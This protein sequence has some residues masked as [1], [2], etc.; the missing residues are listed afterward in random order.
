[1]QDTVHIALGINDPQGDYSRHAGAML[2]SL[3]MHASGPVIAHIIHNDS[4]TAANRQKLQQV[5]QRFGKEV[6]FYPVQ[7]PAS[8]RP[9]AG[10][11]TEG[12]LF[13]LLLPELVSVD[14]II[15]F[16]CDIVVTLDIALLWNIDLAGRPVAAVLDP[17]IPA[18][19]EAV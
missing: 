3:F 8:V 9:L 11:V 15:Y 18:F 4:L 1:M 16:D 2:A 5:A 17:G 14:K 19:P 13:R 6:R 7:L 10:H 12:A